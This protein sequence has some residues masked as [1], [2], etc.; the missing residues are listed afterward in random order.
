LWTFRT[1][2]WVH[3][4]DCYTTCW[5][6]WIY[7]C[8][9]LATWSDAWTSWAVVYA[10]QRYPEL[11]DSFWEGLRALA[12][13]QVGGNLAFVLAA[14]EPPDQLA[15]HSDLGSPFF[16]IFG[17]TAT[18]GPLTEPE[19]RE[20]I[21]SSPVPFPPADV[22]WILTQSGHW[23][24]LLQILCRER[25]ITLEEGETGDAWQEDGL[26][27]AVPFRYLLEVE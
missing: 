23:P 15:D 1:H 11:D 27:Q 14:H 13:N 5:Q 20:L 6:V 22:D 18:L 3:E 25:L 16:N 24:L 7:Q 12:T 10:L 17:Y 2:E 26:Q 21:A 19:A 8:L 9:I 4:K